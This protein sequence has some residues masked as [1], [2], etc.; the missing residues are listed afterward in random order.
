MRSKVTKKIIAIIFTLLLCINSFAAV[1]S[2]NDGSAFITKAEFDSLKNNF[3]SQLDQFNANI[4]NKIDTAIASYLAGITIKKDP[5]N[6]WD[7][8]VSGNGGP[9]WFLNT[10]PG[11]GNNTI[12]PQKKVTLR[13]QMAAHGVWKFKESWKFHSKDASS[14]RNGV[15]AIGLYSVAGENSDGITLSSQWRLYQTRLEYNTK[16]N[17]AWPMSFRDYDIPEINH[18]PS[19]GNW[20]TWWNS[21][22]Y[23]NGVVNSLKTDI[24]ASKIVISSGSGNVWVYHT[25]PTGRHEL[26]EYATDFFPTVTITA[27]LH[28][29]MDF[30]IIAGNNTDTSHADQNYAKFHKWYCEDNGKAYT[31]TTKQTYTLNLPTSWGNEIT[32]SKA[33]KSIPADNST[34][35]N[36]YWYNLTLSQIKTTDNEEYNTFQFGLNSDADI[37]CINDNKFVTFD[38]TNYDNI[39]IKDLSWEDSYYCNTG[40]ETQKNK[41]NDIELKWNEVSF[42]P[43]NHKIYD[44]SNSLLTTVAGDTV[45]NGGGVPIVKALTDC[46]AKIKLKFKTNDAIG[47]IYYQISDKQFLGGAFDSTAKIKE[48]GMVANDVEVQLEKPLEKDNIIWVN[49]Y[50]SDSGKLSTI[51]SLTI[52]S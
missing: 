39:E 12:T 2:D 8:V 20:A 5:L 34:T 48:S 14:H 43:E 28:N 6:L 21:A 42:N 38:P 1:V 30:R 31:T 50:A 19:G 44:F 4:D 40:R 45:Y 33:D 10:L 46:D 37:Y 32:A 11:L 18:T 36:E 7:Q 15:G 17:P 27:Y 3:Q 26:R 16:D 47:N 49:C 25:E 23:N 41:M 22:G 52:I 35:D 13:R 9:M 51:D 24:S 29:Y